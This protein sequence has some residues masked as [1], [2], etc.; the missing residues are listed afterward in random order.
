MRS[1]F[2]NQIKKNRE[3]YYQEY[4]NH[5]FAETSQTENTTSVKINLPEFRFPRLPQIH[6]PDTSG[7]RINSG[8]I[9]KWVLIG[10]GKTTKRIGTALL[11]FGK[12]FNKNIQSIQEH[13]DEK[14]ENIQEKFYNRVVVLY[15]EDEKG[16]QRKSPDT[17][18]EKDH[19]STG[20]TDNAI[21]AILNRWWSQ[22]L[23]SLELDEAT[24]DMRV[25]EKAPINEQANSESE[26]MEKPRQIKRWFRKFIDQLSIVSGKIHQHSLQP[27]INRFIL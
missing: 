17:Y 10:I 6:F 5:V 11:G 3:S 4:G 15:D 22:I 23:I 13:L 26:S 2:F 9:A 21:A 19:R 16:E 1:D 20:K 18:S 25:F 8:K 27:L 7:I 12:Y 24:N 14:A